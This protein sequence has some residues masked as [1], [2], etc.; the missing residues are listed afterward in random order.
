[1]EI[2]GSWAY[3]DKRGDIAVEPQFGVLAWAT[4]AWD[5]LSSRETVVFPHLQEAGYFSNGLALVRVRGRCGYIDKK[6]FMAIG[7][8]FV[9]AGPFSEGLAP[10]RIGARYG[11][12]DRDGRL[13]IELRFDAALL[14]RD[15]LAMV[16]VEGRVGY[17]D[18]DGKYVWKPTR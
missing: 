18:H 10:A 13:V 1:M 6:G 9:L 7:P 8:R 2:G 3:F 12:I 14:F 17:I 11:F 15:G 4:S 5:W 16:W